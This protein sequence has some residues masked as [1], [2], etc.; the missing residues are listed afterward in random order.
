MDRELARAT[1][2]CSKGTPDI[3]KVFGNKKP[4]KPFNKSQRKGR[5]PISKLNYEDLGIAGL[6]L[7]YGKSNHSANECRTEKSNLKCNSCNK[8]GH[9]AKVC[10]AC[11]LADGPNAGPGGRPNTRVNS[12]HQIQDGD[13]QYGIYRVIDVYRNDYA[14]SNAERHYSKIEI[15]GKLIKF[16][17]DSGSGY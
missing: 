14:H 4:P 17:V 15:E 10:I 11:L 6:C 2:N 3:N 9:V 1:T 8:K 16:E 13:A 7:R 5:Q 12:T